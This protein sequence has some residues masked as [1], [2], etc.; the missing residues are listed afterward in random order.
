MVSRGRCC[1]SLAMGRI[2]SVIRLTMLSE[3]EM[4]W[5]LLLFYVLALD[6]AR[7]SLSLSLCRLL[8]RFALLQAVCRDAAPKSLKHHIYTSPCRLPIHFYHTAIC[9]MNLQPRGTQHSRAHTGFFNPSKYRLFVRFSVILY[10]SDHDFYF[11]HLDLQTVVFL[12]W[13]PTYACFRFHRA[14]SL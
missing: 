2:L 9:Q 12:K 7:R 13:Q 4:L 6:T 1:H 5:L 14:L 11:S 8:Q 3:T 10:K